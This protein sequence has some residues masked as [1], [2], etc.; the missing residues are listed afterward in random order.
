MK[1]LLALTLTLTAAFPAVAA[2]PVKKPEMA[3]A[4]LWKKSPFCN[5]PA[6]ARPKPVVNPLADWTLGGVSEIGAGY[7]VMLFHRHQAGESRL[8]RSDEPAGNGDF[9]VESV[10]IVPGDWKRTAVTL[11][12][13]DSV[14]TLYFD[15][16]S[17]IRPATAVTTA[18]AAPVSRPRVA[19]P[20]PQP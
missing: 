19:P 7:Q 16:D 4:L 8:L 10:G 18:P 6:E 11:R 12:S 5:P 3:Y 14:A 17:L 1:T 9:K 13:G 2:V 15:T 20:L